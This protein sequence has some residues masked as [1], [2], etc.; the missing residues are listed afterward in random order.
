MCHHYEDG[1]VRFSLIGPR[2]LNLSTPPRW[3]AGGGGVLWVLIRGDAE[4]PS[5]IV[6]IKQPIS[7]GFGEVSN[8]S[9]KH[10]RRH[11]HSEREE[12]G[13]QLHINYQLSQIVGVIDVNIQFYYFH[14]SPASQTQD[15]KTTAC[16]V[17]FQTV[18]CLVSFIATKAIEIPWE[19][20]T[21]RRSEGIA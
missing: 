1:G 9:S 20:G 11:R 12:G 13:Y 8:W 18:R 21:K 15:S 3:H 6:V 2:Y 4:S 5:V 17:P 14:C 16:L 10:S 7:T 19:S